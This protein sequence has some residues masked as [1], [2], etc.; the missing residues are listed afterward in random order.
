MLASTIHIYHSKFN[1]SIFFPY[2]S[3]V[4]G[5]E[6]NL[7]S[8]L[9]VLV[10]LGAIIPNHCSLIDIYLLTCQKKVESSIF[11]YILLLV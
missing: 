1:H 7:N 9:Y 5:F 4:E 2:K 11:S 3:L 10:T 8:K 6:K